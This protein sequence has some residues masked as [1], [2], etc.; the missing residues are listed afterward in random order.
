MI[1]VQEEIRHLQKV[2]DFFNNNV[3]L[4]KHHQNLN[5]DEQCLLFSCM[6]DNLYP[7]IY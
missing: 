1:I 3:V 7:F 6:Y 2:F 4:C 5:W